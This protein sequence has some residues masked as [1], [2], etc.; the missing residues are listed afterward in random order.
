MIRRREGRCTA[1]QSPS[2]LEFSGPRRW[3]EAS[4]IITQRAPDSFLY[5]NHLCPPIIV[6]DTDKDECAYKALKAQ[7]PRN[8]LRILFERAV[9]PVSVAPDEEYFIIASLVPVSLIDATN[10]SFPRLDG[11]FSSRTEHAQGDVVT[12]QQV[13]EFQLSAIERQN[14]GCCVRAAGCRCATLI[15]RY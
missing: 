8:V 11:G 14:L 12:W 3:P 10:S 15:M 4:S 6:H 1:A 7:E 9:L 5:E 13:T 2:R